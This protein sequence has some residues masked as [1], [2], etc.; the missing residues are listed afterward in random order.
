MRRTGRKMKKKMKVTA[1]LCCA[2]SVPSLA[3]AQNAATLVP[4][5]TFGVN[6]YLAP[7]TTNPYV[8]TGST[9]RGLAFN[10][11]GV[12]QGTGDVYSGDLYLT[13]RANVNGS[14][15]NIAI[16][17]A[18]TGSV[19][20]TLDT[21]GISGGNTFAIDSIAVAADGAIYVNNLTTN[22]SSS[23]YKIYRY[24]NEQVATGPSASGPTT[25]FSGNVGGA[26]VGDDLAVYGTGT[27]TVL[28]S[29]FGSGG[30]ITNGYGIT[31]ITGPTGNTTTAVQVSGVN[32]HDFSSSL[33]FGGNANTVFGSQI[34]S[35]TA[36]FY[37]DSTY[38][39][40][41]TTGTLV[42][43]GSLTNAYP[44]ATGEHLLAY[45]VVDGVPILAAQSTGD[46][47]VSI[48]DVTN[49]LAPVLLAAG[50]SPTGETGSN[51]NATGNVVFGSVYN[52][53]QVNLYTLSTGEGMAAYT[54]T[55]TPAPVNLTY[56]NANGNFDNGISASFN[57]SSGATVFQSGNYV[58]FDDSYPSGSYT[59]PVSGTVSPGATTFNNS[60]G[61]YV[62]TGANSSSGI[63][64]TGSLTKYG[65][66]SVTLLTS[67]SY[68]GGTVVNAGTLT[69]GAANA[70]PVN[71]SLN[72]A[73]GAMV[74]I[75]NHSTNAVFVPQLSSLTNSGTI[76]ITNNALIVHN[77]SIGTITAEVA[78]AFNGG[79]WTGTNASSGVITS[80][81]AAANTRHLTAVGVATGLSTFE[82][83]TVANTDVLVKYTYYGDANLDGKVDG[84]DY[85]LIDSGY[86]TGAT[87]WQNGDFNYDGVVNGSDYTLIDNAF[88]SQGAQL[89]NLIASPQAVST[90]QIAGTS[91]V[92]EPA[93][94][95]LLG[96]GAM[97]LVGRRRR[98]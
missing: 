23:A 84:S 47:H 80:S 21:A 25:A 56:L 28:A 91:A 76:D 33:A 68:T 93:T 17:S 64:G 89:A 51:G 29:G 67:N 71:T 37:R 26:R 74:T 55:V 70:F 35:G 46:D 43:T 96:L 62:V 60:L 65:T 10:P 72:I 92:P 18:T 20:G 31:T 11:L 75:A 34:G 86:L 53:N 1:A 24:A 58:T 12:Y 6:G 79:T 16:L 14:S 90:A 3:L 19:L 77:G 30:T 88:N 38:V 22:S 81:I 95:G 85:S 87:G 36:G 63:A 54:I 5:S 94:L 32:S 42:G 49:P 44:Y 50:S 52:T 82:G 9:E 27:S 78:A 59:V 15:V 98:R 48:Y 66:G 69:F 97:G 73:S 39:A 13:S 7:G 83:S 61:N 40:G 57:G 45:D 8:T 4:L 41:N 2:A